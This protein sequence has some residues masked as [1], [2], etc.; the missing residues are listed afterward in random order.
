VQ[1]Q[2]PPVEELTVGLVAHFAFCPRRAWLEAEGEKT[3]TAQMAIGTVE[4]QVTDDPGRGRA[5]VDRGVDICHET[6]VY[7]GR[8]DTIERFT[9]GSVGIVEYK[10]TP[11]RRRP[12]VTEPMVV[13]VALQAMALESMGETV[14]EGSIYFL[15]HH[16]RITVDLS[17]STRDHARE[18]VAATRRCLSSSEAPAPLEDDPKCTRCSH[19][20]VCLPDERQLAPVRRRIVVA[21]PDTQVVHLTTA[22]SLASLRQGRMLV[23]HDHEEIASVPLE[24][25]QGVVVHGNVDLTGGLIRE[26]LWRDLSIVWCSSRG[27]IVGYA[28]STQSP[29]GGPRAQQRSAAVNGRLDLA[30]EFVS[31][32][33]SNQATL[34]RRNGQTPDVI[35]RLRE[36]AQKAMAAASVT[37]LFGVEG[38]AGKLY[39]DSFGSM[40]KTPGWDFRVRQRRP[41]K[42]S[43]NAA[44]NYAYALL[45]ADC[46]VAIRSCG[47]DPH[48]GFLHSSNRNKPALA[49][50]LCEEFRAPV[51]DSCVL[52]AINNHELTASDFSS[53]LESTSLR[54]TGR[55][56]LTAAYEQRMISEFTHPVFGYKVTWRRAIEVQARLILGVLDGSQD[57]YVGVRIR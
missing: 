13:Q 18:L 57:R 53:R 19:V 21:D 40:I 2:S 51:A 56:K 25:V 30:Q 1:S 32:K 29:N 52:R 24:R 4:H 42:D 46:I 44:L 55:K 41:A 15:E 20:S 43:V 39:F 47:L 54:D 28:S 11:I 33:I 35:P 45:V 34:L 48:A 38:E 12:E 49:L 22:G 8:C 10:A 31:A 23:R 7:T 17:P 26:L 16:Q 9:D 5:R 37:E 6:L 36:L 3:D 14:K 50:D 27:R